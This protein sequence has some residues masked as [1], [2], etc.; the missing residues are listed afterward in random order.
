MITLYGLSTIADL[1]LCSN[2][3]PHNHPRQDPPVSLRFAPA[4]MR[5]ET[6]VPGAKQV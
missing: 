2:L 6:D 3:E 5:I 1:Y 4:N